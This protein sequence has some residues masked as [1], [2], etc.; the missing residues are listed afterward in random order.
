MTLWVGLILAL[1]ASALFNVG[2]G[3]QALE[4]RQAPPEQALRASLLVHLVKRPRWLLGFLLGGVGALVEIAA[5]ANAP[6]IVVEPVLA[7]GLLLL[8]AIGQRELGE[9]VSRTV[10]LGVVAIIVGTGLIAWGAPPHSE[11]HRGTLDLTTVT[12]CMGLAS[13]AP[14]LLRGSR[15]SSPMLTNVASA[16][17]FASTNLAAKLLADDIDT[18]HPRAA[19]IWLAVAI[20]A[21]ILGTLTGMTALQQLPATTAVPVSTAVQT[22]L[23][24]ALEPLIFTESW[25]AAELEGAVLVAG[26]VVMA[27][28]TVLVARSRSVS[29]MVAS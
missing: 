14:F 25:R 4:A 19:A 27:V 29:E 10:V 8:L 9:E 1:L 28:G 23:P 12:I 3:L 16:F 13:L 5:F 2:I 21:G 20:V 22:F 15:L 7:A 11:G 6:F 24:V 17:G 18:G 26:L